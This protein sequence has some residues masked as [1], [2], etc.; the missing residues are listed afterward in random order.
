MF[1][2]DKRIICVKLLIIF[3]YKLLSSSLKYLKPK[4]I[5]DIIMLR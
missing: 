5:F 4:V 3:T 1:L 2:T